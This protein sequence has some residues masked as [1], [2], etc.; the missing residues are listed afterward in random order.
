MRRVRFRWR[1]SLQILGRLLLFLALV[2]AWAPGVVVATEPVVSAMGQ[3]GGEFRLEIKEAAG[4]V[5]VQE[6]R[7]FFRW[8]DLTFEA[9]AFTGAKE[10]ARSCDEWEPILPNA[11]GHA[12]GSSAGTFNE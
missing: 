8:D 2:P 11:R 1:V 5:V 4:G 10:T 9:E 12:S 6:S 7:D 3:S